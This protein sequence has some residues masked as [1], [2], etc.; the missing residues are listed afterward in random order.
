MPSLR[1]KNKCLLSKHRCDLKSHIED[2]IP[3]RYRVTI[4]VNFPH[5]ISLLLTHGSLC[6]QGG[7]GGTPWGPGRFRWKLH[8][9]SEAWPPI[10]TSSRGETAIAKCPN[11][12]TFS[13]A[14]WNLLMT[15]DVFLWGNWRP[16]CLG[17]CVKKRRQLLICFDYNEICF[18]KLSWHYNWFRW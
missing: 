9:S 11:Y 4:Y 14:L 5:Y 3:C 2:Q 17:Q 18:L 7:A 16:R 12:D 6:T 1:K 8:P 13:L 10:S 15:F